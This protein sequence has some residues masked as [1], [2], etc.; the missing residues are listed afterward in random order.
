MDIDVDFKR[1]G[2][3]PADKLAILGMQAL[4]KLAPAFMT[5]INTDTFMGYTVDDTKMYLENR[6]CSACD[7]KRGAQFLKTDFVL[8]SAKGY[9][10]A[11]ACTEDVSTCYRACNFNNWAPAAVAKRVELGAPRAAELHKYF[12]GMEINSIL[13]ATAVEE[14]KELAPFE[15]LSLFCGP[16]I[17]GD[18][19][20]KSDDGQLVEA[21]IAC[22]HF[23]NAARRGIMA[24][25]GFKVAKI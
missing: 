19:S 15:Q 16:A 1:F 20:V 11:F 13:W 18:T 21:S 25:K 5:R 6:R 14:C 9:K 4:T 10:V 12:P 3:E 8:D 24:G 23:V 2:I 7:A 22:R 17:F